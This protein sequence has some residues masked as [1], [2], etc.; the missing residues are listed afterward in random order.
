MNPPTAAPPASM[1]EH[2]APHRERIA[3]WSLWLGIFLAPAGW[4]VQLTV[5]TFAIS[6]GCFPKDQPLGAPITAFAPFVHGADLFALVLGVVAALVALSNWRKTREEKPGRGHHLIE[7]GDGRTRFMS[8]SGMLVSG[9]V[10]VAVVYTVL[11]H[12]ALT[13]CGQ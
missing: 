5:D 9:M 13:G 10:L 3:L 2:P 4:F 8:M 1:D 12:F 6:Q 11:S 7:S